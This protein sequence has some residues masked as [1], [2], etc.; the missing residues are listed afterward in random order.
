MRF[1]TILGIG[2]AFAVLAGGAA[3]AYAWRSEIAPIATP[4]PTSFD[5]E[6]V[7]RGKALALIGDCRTCH[8]AP[9][10]RVFAGGL[11]MPTPF[12]IIYS[13]NITPDRETGIGSW[14]PEAF[15]RAMREGVDRQGRH[16]YP[17]FPYDHFTLTNSEDIK[18]LYAY[19]MTREPVS[20]KAPANQLPFPI[21][22]RLVL[23]GWKLLFLDQKELQPD[24][25]RDE[26]WNRG[27]YLVEGLGH[28]GGCHTPRNLMG[29]EE[30]AHAFE[31]GEVEGWR[32][33]ALGKASKAPIPWTADALETYLAEGFHP[34]HGVA[35]GPMAAVAENL[36][37]VPRQ[38]LAAMAAYLAS[39]GPAAASA[40]PTAVASPSMPQ[41]GGLQV[42]TPPAQSDSGARLYGNACAS[43]HDSGRTLPLGAVPLRVS[44]AVSGEGPEN[45]VMLILNGVPATNSSTAPVMPGFGAVM[46]DEQI[47]S[48]ARYLRRDLAGRSEWPSLEAT[49]QEAR[50]A[51]AA[52]RLK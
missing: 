38:E 50:A 13:T 1:K 5:P 31:G 52:S 15:A 18:A 19:F 9:A 14:S 3:L 26:Q 10:G 8:T 33:Y 4:S 35:R 7:A 49:L 46:T 11:A 28:C 51:R 23:A 17:A 36:S 29:A 21:S 37:Q 45:L 47:M 12:G 40:Q 20:A 24:P 27:R 6:L 44:T 30:K 16:L 41:S 34:D 48:L 22:I 2:A 39:P 42:A 43:C 32:A 25:A